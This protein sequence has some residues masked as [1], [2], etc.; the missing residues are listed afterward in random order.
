MDLDDLVQRQE[1]RV[2]ARRLLRELL[3]SFSAPF[4]ATSL[5]LLEFLT[6]LGLH[7]RRDNQALPISAD[8]EWSVDVH[9]Q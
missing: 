8:V 5:G 9:L 6:T 3:E 7:A 2:H 1:D 4:I